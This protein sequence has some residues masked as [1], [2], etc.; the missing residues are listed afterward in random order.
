MFPWLVG[1][2]VWTAKLGGRELSG[3]AHPRRG[4][5]RLWP[6]HA[7]HEDQTRERA[8]RG[9]ARN[10]PLMCELASRMLFASCRSVFAGVVFFGFSRRSDTGMDTMHTHTHGTSFSVVS[11]IICMFWPCQGCCQ[12]TP[13]PQ[14]SENFCRPGKRRSGD[15]ADGC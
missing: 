14:N 12:W 3:P 13:S 11:N 7:I 1:W 5:R 15:A 10:M 9:M 8:Q 6:G 2:L 4:H